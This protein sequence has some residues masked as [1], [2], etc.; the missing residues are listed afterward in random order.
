MQCPHCGQP[1]VDTRRLVVSTERIQQLYEEEGMSLQRIADELHVS[2][3][4]IQRRL[5][6]LGIPRRQKGWR[7]ARR[8]S[9]TA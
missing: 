7:A 3:H 6:D 2:A 1:L 9:G 5:E 4:T 8:N